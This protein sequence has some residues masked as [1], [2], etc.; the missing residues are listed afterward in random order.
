M[1]Y[2]PLSLRDISPVTEAVME[3]GGESRGADNGLPLP[4]IAPIVGRCR[5][6]T[7]G[8]ELNIPLTSPAS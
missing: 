3:E 4:T 2:A 8:Q 7:E 1:G 6:A 5:A